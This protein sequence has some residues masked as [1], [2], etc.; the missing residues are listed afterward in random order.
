MKKVVAQEI[1][2]SSIKQIPNGAFLV[3][4]AKN[5]RNVM[6]IGWALFGFV[7]RRST[8]MVAVRNSR[9]THTLLAEAD[10]F[11]VSIPSGQMERELNFCGSKSGRDFDKFKE[12]ALLTI[13]TEIVESPLLNIPGYHYQCRLIYKSPM[14][15]RFLNKDLMP[16]YPAKDYHTLYFGEI[17]AAYTIP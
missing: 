17:L 5:R 15:P 8:L 12:C 11:A 7:W 6:T 14:D 4:Q 13:D 1:M 3:V 16:I 10:S 2:G 9:F